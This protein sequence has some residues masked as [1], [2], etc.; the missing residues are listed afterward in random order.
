MISEA[1]S[2]L[3]PESETV[4]ALEVERT[5]WEKATILHA[6]YHRSATQLIPDR[7]ARHYSDFASLWNHSSRDAALSRIDLLE[8]VALFKS[9]FFGSSWSNY[10]SARPGSLRLSPSENR[11][12]ELERD[13]EDMKPMFLEEPPS[14]AEVLQILRV[15]EE[16]INR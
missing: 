7:F 16:T 8:R 12:R 14:F 2:S 15:A 11:V 6:E 13:Y 4:V 10:D 5:F 3:K 1:L 9:S